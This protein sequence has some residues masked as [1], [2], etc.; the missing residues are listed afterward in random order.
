MT[1][2]LIITCLGLAASGPATTL[3]L[4]RYLRTRDEQDTMERRRLLVHI[5][6]P[7]TAAALAV[8]DDEP[9]TPGQL[10]TSWDNDEEF[11]A[12]KAEGS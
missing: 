2:A 12:A 3:I 1:I 11:F 6:A 7:D 8:A 4:V 5:Q 10:Y 9:E